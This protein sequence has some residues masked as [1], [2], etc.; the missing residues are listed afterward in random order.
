MGGG[1]R[2]DRGGPAVIFPGHRTTKPWRGHAGPLEALQWWS[3]A[4]EAHRARLGLRARMSCREAIVARC[5]VAAGG[6]GQ[7][8]LC[9][10]LYG[11]PG[12]EDWDAVAELEDDELEAMRQAWRAQLPAMMEVL[13]WDTTTTASGA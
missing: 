8:T 11:W 7:M 2:R 9:T 12:K 4:S 5:E 6:S 13:G 10:A 3:G 1:A